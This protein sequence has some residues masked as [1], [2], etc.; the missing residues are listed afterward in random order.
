MTSLFMRG[1][2]FNAFTKFFNSNF[3]TDRK[4]PE[5]AAAAAVAAAVKIITEVRFLRHEECSS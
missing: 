1:R 3:Y 4:K 2:I 5:A